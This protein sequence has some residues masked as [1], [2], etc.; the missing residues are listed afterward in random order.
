MAAGLDGAKLMAMHPHRKVQKVCHIVGEGPFCEIVREHSC[1]LQRNDW[2]C[3]TAAL[4]NM[5]SLFC[6]ACLGKRIACALMET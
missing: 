3:A 4:C 5:M 6:S 2:K 1:D